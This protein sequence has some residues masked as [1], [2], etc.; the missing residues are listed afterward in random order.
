MRVPLARSESHRGPEGHI[1]RLISQILVQW[2]NT[3]GIP[4]SMFCRILVFMWSV[5][6]LSQKIWKQCPSNMK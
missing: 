3:K 2:P 4:E 1:N 5:G 6:A